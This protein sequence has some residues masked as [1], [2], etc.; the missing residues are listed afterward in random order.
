MVSQTLVEELRII[1]KE[2]YGVELEM[3][4][5]KEVADTLVGFFDILSEVEYQDYVKH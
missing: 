5:A 4:E 2:D 3:K 1:I